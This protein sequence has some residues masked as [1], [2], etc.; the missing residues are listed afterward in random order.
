[1]RALFVIFSLLGANEEYS[2]FVTAASRLFEN[3]EYERALDQLGNAKKYAKTADEQTEVALYEGVV[4]LELGRNDDAR[5]A[6]QTALY[7]SPDAKVP[8]KVSPK[9]LAQVEAI[10]AQVKR[11]L[12]PILARREEEEREKER[13]RKAAEEAAR[14]AKAAELVKPPPPKEE[15]PKPP[16]VVKRDT[17][18]V[19]EPPPPVLEP[20]PSVEEPKP[21]V[22]A[23]PPAPRKKGAPIVA[24][25]F[26]AGTAGAGITAAIFGSQSKG[27]VMQ[28]EAAMWQAETQMALQDAQGKATL[29]NVLFAATGALALGAL[30]SAI[31]W[32]ASE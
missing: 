28:A 26:L 29:A 25:V 21:V 32:A 7:L 14:L 10:R 12:A 17:P 27:L 3:L 4:L 24:L 23:E 8:V 6:L 2:R 22:T 31:I 18:K 20:Q 30:I 15:Q 13:K 19:E 16:V 1:M 9:V 5:A 11:D